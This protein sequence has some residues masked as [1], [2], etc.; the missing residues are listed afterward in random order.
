MIKG[1]HVY[2]IVW[3]LVCSVGLMCF[4]TLVAVMDVTVAEDKVIPMA[5]L[6]HLGGGQS[7]RSEW[8]QQVF[9]WVG[10]G[11]FQ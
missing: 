6:S 11:L 10:L 5:A 9:Q 3:C 8:L 2:A 1:S 7:E 4:S